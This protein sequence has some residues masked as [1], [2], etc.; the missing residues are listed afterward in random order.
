MELQRQG[1]TL[2]PGTSLFDDITGTYWFPKFAAINMMLRP[3][4]NRFCLPC[5]NPTKKSFV[6]KQSH[7]RRV[8]CYRRGFLPTV[9]SPTGTLN[10]P[11]SIKCTGVSSMELLLLRGIHHIPLSPLFPPTGEDTWL[12][13][14]DELIYC[15]KQIWDD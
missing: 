5:P 4:N 3:R 13:T 10:P 6:S 1:T 11:C 9:Q 15:E 7:A 8:P 14:G 2:T 12:K